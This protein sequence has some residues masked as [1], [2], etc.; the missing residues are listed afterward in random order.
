MS[1]LRLPKMG[2]PSWQ[3][4]VRRARECA[5][6]REARRALALFRSA[7]GRDWP[8]WRLQYP[9]VRQFFTSIQ[10]ADPE[11]IQLLSNALACTKTSEPRHVRKV[12]ARL[13][14]E[15]WSAYEGASLEFKVVA[16][17]LKE[18]FSAHLLGERDGGDL[19]AV[20]EERSIKVECK[21]LQPRTDR[22]NFDDFV[23]AAMDVCAERLEGV[24]R[25]ELYFPGCMNDIIPYL[26]EVLATLHELAEQPVALEKHWA[27]LITLRFSPGEPSGEVPFVDGPPIRTSVNRG[28]HLELVKLRRCLRS[29]ESQLRGSDP[30]L[31]A[32][33]VRDL[34]DTTVEAGEIERHVNSS[35]ADLP[36][37]GGVLCMQEDLLP[38]GL[39]KPT[40]NESE[41]LWLVVAP[42]PVGLRRAALFVRNPA[43][44][45]R[46]S[47]GEILNLFRCFVRG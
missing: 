34:L 31:F 46:V 9:L 42:S 19:I 1:V 7:V 2:R 45:L 30:A 8:G 32:V 6:P 40:R 13:G 47:D 25:T 4:G 44:S 33:S 28:D 27:G 15:T 39:Q 29:H 35:I 11:G 23:Q 16:A 37:V 38:S 21:V 12:L 17:C 24:G 43:A 5:R 3:A 20:L 22:D 14:G 18:G 10:G 36:H 41:T 26:A